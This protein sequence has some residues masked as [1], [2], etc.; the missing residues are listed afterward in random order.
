MGKDIGPDEDNHFG[1]DEFLQ[2]CEAVGTDPQ[3]T[4]NVGS[5][6]PQEAAEWVEYCNGPKDSKWGAVRA[7][8]GH[9]QPYG[10]K[11]WF[12]GNEIFGLHEVGN[13]NPNTYVKTVKDFST[14]MRKIDPAIKI[15]GCG[16]L[17]PP[18][19]RDNIN[20]TVL[21]GAGEHMDYLSVHLYAVNPFSDPRNILNYH[22]LK[23]HR[24]K[25]KLLYYDI[26]GSLRTQQKFL[27][28]NTQ[29]VRNHAQAGR[30]V[31]L[32]FDEWGLWFVNGPDNVY[33]NYNLRDG[34]WAAASLNMFHRFAPDIPLANIAQMVNCLGVITSTN[35]GTFLTPTGLAF[36]V[37]TEKAG[38]TLLPSKVD[39]PNLPLGA[40][41]PSLDI[42]ATRRGNKISLFMVNLHLDKD[43]ETDIEIKGLSVNQSANRTDLH[44]SDAF[45]YNTYDSPEAVRLNERTESLS[46][47]RAGTSSAFTVKLAPHSLSCLELDVEE[48]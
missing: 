35:E 41:W 8:N 28:H 42:S 40:R 10:V 33:A 29:D 11:Y 12:I 38:D 25:S 4:V 45:L 20:P 37:Y 13:Q 6:S 18:G 19:I 23:L 36:K 7:Q 44:H 16:T 17:F 2:L 9:S 48:I 43:I 15:I 27:N 14:A 24:R 30:K 32:S 5:G 39:C 26:L 47:S 21:K 46:I 31:P 3:I 34:I 1:T 22:T